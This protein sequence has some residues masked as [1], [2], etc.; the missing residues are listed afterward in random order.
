MTG[1]ILQGG[2]ARGSYQIGAYYA[3]KKMHIHFDGICGTSIGSFNGA[4]IASGK[5]KELLE[6]WKEVSIGN[7]LGFDKQFVE[8]KVNK[9]HDFTYYKSSFKNLMQ[10][11]KSKG[12]NTKGLEEVLN[13]YVDYNTLINSKIDYGLCTVRLND[14]KPIYIFKDKMN[15]KNMKDYILASCYLPIFRLEKKVDNHYYIDGGFYDN[16]P[17]N[18]LIEKGYEKIYVVELNPLIN[19]SQ[20]VKKK[21]E[22][23]KITPKR[24]L[25]G[26]I[27]YSHD[28][29]IENIKMGYYDTLRVIKKLDGY[30]YCFKKMPSF[31][32]NFWTSKLEPVLLRKVMG[33]LN[34]KNAKEACVK[35]MEY[36]M[37]QEHIDFYQIY[38]PRKMLK[39]LQKLPEKKNRVYQFVKQLKVL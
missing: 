5:K 16:T 30:H 29:M 39:N 31:F 28:S 8:K 3:L 11:I 36:I 4:L 34:A 2:G 25:G 24:S 15:E 19:I 14:L 27:N 7:L 1:L 35:A 37:K 9:E 6:F 13:K 32:Y 20:K 17:I 38:S 10:I 22:I 18:M 33:E 21:V 12:I 23:I 26:V